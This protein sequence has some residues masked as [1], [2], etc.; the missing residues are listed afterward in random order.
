MTSASDF[1]WTDEQFAYARRLWLDGD[2]ARVIA[3]KMNARWHGGLTRNA[4]IGKLRRAGAPMRVTAGRA[5]KPKKVK[6]KKIV[7]A[8]IAKPPALKPVRL[9]AAAETLARD[10]AA[11]VT[12]LEMRPNQCRWPYGDPLAPD[13]VFCGRPRAHGAYCAGHV[14]EALSFEAAKRADAARAKRD[15]ARAQGERL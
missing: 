13:F 11:A 4:V 8:K 6:E 9:A 3:E 5:V 7:L 14:R 15:A 10:A 1:P 2:S 12:L